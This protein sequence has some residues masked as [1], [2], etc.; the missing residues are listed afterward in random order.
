MRLK[1]RRLAKGLSRSDVAKVV[2]SSEVNIWNYENGKYIPKYTTAFKLAKLFDCS[3]E[4][5]MS[6][7]KSEEDG[8]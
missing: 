5:I 1:E 4:D 3:I 7:C 8:S 6:G 2:G